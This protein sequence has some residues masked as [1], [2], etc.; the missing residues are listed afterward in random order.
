MEFIKSNPAAISSDVI[1]FV[2]NEE[3]FYEDTALM[4]AANPAA[5]NEF[6]TLRNDFKKL[7]DES[8]EFLFLTNISPIIIVTT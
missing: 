2:S 8:E 1:E 4:K 3:D 7:F 6:K 5:S